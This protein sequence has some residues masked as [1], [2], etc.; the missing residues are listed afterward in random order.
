MATM[1]KKTKKSHVAETVDDFQ[2]F[3]SELQDRFFGERYSEWVFRG[4]SKAN[5]DLRPAIGREKHTESSFA[6]FEE[7]IFSLFKRESAPFIALA[8]QND[9]EWLALAQHHG[10]PTR[11]LDW[12]FNPFI[13]LYFAVA[14][15]P[16]EDGALWALRAPKRLSDARLLEGQPFSLDGDRKFLPRSI[17]PRFQNQEG[18]FIIRSDPE[19]CMTDSLRDDWELT[20]FQIKNN[21]KEDIQYYLFRLGI[22]HG[23]LFPDLVGLCE[24]L[25]WRH[26]IRPAEAA[27]K[28]VLNKDPTE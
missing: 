27:A 6:K 14:Q 3:F 28:D 1:S 22:H 7:S 25:K 12:S 11:L 10:L 9:Y 24:H 26:T 23:K 20:K 17:S 13:A 16:D 18:L 2:E 19:T 21:L 4:H 8:L 5:Y 15:N